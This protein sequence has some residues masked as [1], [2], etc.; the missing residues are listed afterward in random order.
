VPEAEGSHAAPPGLRRRGALRPPA[1]PRAGDRGAAPRLR[2]A[3]RGDAG[4]VAADAAH[5][6][7]DAS[8]PPEAAEAPGPDAAR[9]RAVPAADRRPVLHRRV[10]P[11]SGRGPD[12]VTLVGNSC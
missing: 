11:G 5:G 1:P 4:P 8:V 6:A 9:R 2:A 12:E 7:A 3:V 10:Q